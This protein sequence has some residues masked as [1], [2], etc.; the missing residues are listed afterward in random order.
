[1][2][3]ANSHLDPPRMH[4]LD[5]K[6]KV[7]VHRDDL[8]RSPHLVDQD[9]VQEAGAMMV[10]EA[11]NFLLM[12]KAMNVRQNTIVRIPRFAMNTVSVNLHLDPQKMH[13]LD[14]NLHP[15]VL[16][17]EARAMTA[18]DHSLL[19]VSA[20]NAR[21][22]TIVLIL[23]FAMNTVSANWHLDQPKMLDLD[24][25]AKVEVIVHRDDPAPSRHLV[26]L[27]LTAMTATDLRRKW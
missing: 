3:S 23:R 18:T 15:V 24:R 16:D 2:E 25:R 13:D 20:M 19:M 27:V 6:A 14:R 9:L 1:M 4:D 7:E 22:S 21:R 5:R 17:L 8:V 12:V 11:L 26:D 10:T